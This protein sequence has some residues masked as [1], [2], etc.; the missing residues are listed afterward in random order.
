MTDKRV[1]Y[2]EHNSEDGYKSNNENQS[3]SKA[4]SYKNKRSGKSNVLY[5][6][7]YLSQIGFIMVASVAIGVF[8]GKVLDDLLGTTPLLL[9]VFSLIGVGAA[10]RNI[11]TMSTKQV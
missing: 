6:I 8:L 10:I 2:D 9:L 7:T 3:D 1:N 4:E 11:Y 5:A